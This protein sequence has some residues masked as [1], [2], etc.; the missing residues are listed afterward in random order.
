MTDWNEAALEPLLTPRCVAQLKAIGGGRQT[1]W[2]PEHCRLSASCGSQLLAAVSK[3]VVSV[4][5]VILWV[6][7][8]PR[9]PRHSLRLNSTRLYDMYNRRSLAMPALPDG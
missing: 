8:L 3:L 2:A 6:A 5:V 1:C 4:F 9:L 7:T